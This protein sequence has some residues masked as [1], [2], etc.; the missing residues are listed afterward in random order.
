MARSQSLLTLATEITGIAKTFL[1]TAESNP[2]IGTVSGV[3]F[4][5]I[6][7]RFKIIDDG[8]FLAGMGLVGVIDIASAAQA[9]G[10]AVGTA[11]AGVGNIVPADIV[12]FT[13]SSRTINIGSQEALTATSPNV[14]NSEQRASEVT[15]GT[16]GYVP[17]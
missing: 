9:V 16:K 6:L 13:S 7:H 2:V 12:P 4:I 14:S 15:V 5:G 1:R 17:E 11:S 8:T 3:A 10:N